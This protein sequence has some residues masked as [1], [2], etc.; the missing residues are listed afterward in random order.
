M[1]NRHLSPKELDIFRRKIV[2]A[3]VNKN[4]R[5]SMVA[6][7]YGFTKAS[8]NRYVQAYRKYGEKSFEYKPRGTP[9]GYG[10]RL[11]NDNQEEIQKA[12]E[13]K[14]PDQLGMKCVLWTRKAVREYIQSKYGVSY[15]VRSMTDVLNR[16]GFTPQKPLKVAIQQ[17]SV[18]V[19]KWLTEEYAQIKKRSI[20]EGAAIYWGDEMGL[21]STDQRGR[22]YGRKG[23]TPSI[24]KTGSRFR[25]NMI[26]AITNQ[27]SMKW[28]VFENSFTVDVFIDFMRRLTYKS[29]KKIF[30]ILDNHRVHHAKKV[31]NWVEKYSSR[32]QLFFLPPYSPE[33]NP[34]ELVNQ[35]IKSNAG[36][37]K[38]MTSMQDLTIN[39]R[40]YLTQI[41]FNSY[42]IQSY[43]QKDSVKYAA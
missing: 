16:W 14:T 9:K 7:L 10:N 20:E 19:Q 22:T 35:D 18:R 30:L 12:I 3:V 31:T 32:I 1:D 34:Q 42:K 23:K 24:R 36:N 41:Q 37:F 11:S 8:V 2:D 13:H 38:L 33:M 15:A 17:D 39:L 29:P 27:G 26:S 28:K 21:S 4:Y 6:E 43:F 5:Q 25:C 40:Y